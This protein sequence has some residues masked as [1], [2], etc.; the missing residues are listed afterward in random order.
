RQRPGIGHVK[1]QLDRTRDLVD[2]LPARTRRTHEAFDQFVIRN[3]QLAVDFEHAAI[4]AGRRAVRR[5]R[6]HSTDS[7]CRVARALPAESTRQ[8]RSKTSWF[9]RLRRGP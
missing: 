4:L 6:S 7:G 1:T 2:V 5:V 8:A 9:S 3:L